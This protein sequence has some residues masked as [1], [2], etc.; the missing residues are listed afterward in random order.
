M[1]SLKCFSDVFTEKCPSN[2]SH[3]IVSEEISRISGN[4]SAVPSLQ[5]KAKDLNTKQRR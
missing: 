4:V 1:A 3:L 5:S 2:E